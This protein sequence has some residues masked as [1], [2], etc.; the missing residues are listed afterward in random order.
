MNVTPTVK[1]NTPVLV[2]SIIALALAVSTLGYVVIAPARTHS[3]SCTG[4]FT[5][6]TNGT[7]NK[8]RAPIVT[9]PSVI[10][11][12]QWVAQVF[13]KSKIALNLRP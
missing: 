7:Q 1:S 11:P 5:N 10:L 4:T 9:E 2:L 13:P 6:T 3:G 8:A 12:K